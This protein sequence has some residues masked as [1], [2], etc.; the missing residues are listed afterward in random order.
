MASIM[1]SVLQCVLIVLCCCGVG[2]QPFPTTTLR[3][4]ELCLYEEV[5]YRTNELYVVLI[6]CI[7]IFAPW[8]RKAVSQ[9][10]AHRLHLFCHSG[11]TLIQR[12]GDNGK[13]STRTALSWVPVFT[14]NKAMWGS[15]VTYMMH[16]ESNI[17][18]VGKANC[19]LLHEGR[20]DHWPPSQL[21]FVGYV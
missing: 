7:E 1:P 3:I 21:V 9:I 2:K 4:V 11:R 5:L 19:E 14:L 8:R 20:V 13:W 12:I 15:H 10:A 6:F 18:Q 16:T 17:S